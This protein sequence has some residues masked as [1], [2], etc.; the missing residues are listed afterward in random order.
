M[1]D[2]DLT[3]DGS[4]DSA[5][6]AAAVASASDGATAAAPAFS[7]TSFGYAGVSDGSTHLLAS[8]K[9]VSYSRAATGNVILT[10]Q[11]AADGMRSRNVTLALGMGSSAAA[12]TNNPQDSARLSFR[13]ISA[14][15]PRGWRD[16]LSTVRAAP[17]SLPI[18]AFRDLY[19]SGATNRVCPQ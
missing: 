6:A 16:Y 17:S 1:A 15:Y 5:S 13:A 9:L 3:N 14:D 4:N 2:P 12:A 18:T 7:R 10:E 8:K 11:T 19:H